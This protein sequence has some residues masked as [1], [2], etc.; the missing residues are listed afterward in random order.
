MSFTDNNFSSFIV[1]SYMTWNIKSAKRKTALH[2]TGVRSNAVDQQ[3]ALSKQ[4]WSAII[5]TTADFVSK[6]LS[7][8]QLCTNLKCF[9][10]FYTNWNG[11]VPLNEDW[12]KKFLFFRNFNFSSSSFSIHIF[13]F[14]FVLVFKSMIIL[15]LV[16][17]NWL[18]IIIV[19]VSVLVIKIALDRSFTFLSQISKSRDF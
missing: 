6:P 2:Y 16:S 18:P 19:L 9:S 10:W 3:I 14:D 15:V 8:K 4:I 7:S 12:W 1:I 13:D 11:S 5:S 17:S